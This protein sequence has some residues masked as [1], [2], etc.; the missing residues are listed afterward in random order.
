MKIP[1]GSFELEIPQATLARGL[2]VFSEDKVIQCE[3]VSASLFV[4]TVEGTSEYKVQLNLD[5]QSNVV[6]ADCDCPAFKPKSL[7]KHVVG[8]MFFMN[9]GQF[10]I[11]VRPKR[12]SSE[13][14]KQ[15]TEKLKYSKPTE[16]D[17]LLQ[18]LEPLPVDELKKIICE[19]AKQDKVIKAQLFARYLSASSDQTLERF[20]REIQAIIQLNRGKTS[21]NDWYIARII[22]GQMNGLFKNAQ[23]SYQ[24]G[25]VEAAFNLS[26]AL[27]SEL[28]PVFDYSDDSSGD[29]S[30]LWNEIFQWTEQLVRDRKDQLAGTFVNFALKYCHKGFGFDFGANLVESTFEFLVDDKDFKKLDKLFL[31]IRKGKESDYVKELSYLWE[32]NVLNL[33]GQSELAMRF[34]YEN[35]AMPNMRCILLDDLEKRNEWEE[36]LNLALEGEKI[37]VKNHRYNWSH[38]IEIALRHLGKNEELIARKLKNFE[39]SGF[40]LEEWV[41]F[42]KEFGQDSNELRR[43]ML[44][45][46]DRSNTMATTALAI[47]QYEE[48]FDRIVKFIESKPSSYVI[49]AYSDLIKVNLPKI[50]IKRHMAVLTTLVLGN[51]NSYAPYYHDAVKSLKS[52]EDIIPTEELMSYFENSER[53]N[54]KK[55]VYKEIL[56]PELI[57]VL[58][59]RGMKV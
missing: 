16:E 32:Y 43:K 21:R 57:R 15:S 55:K 50:F 30:G 35:R 28:M 1:L 51:H 27:L 20:Q 33:R 14:K 58:E 36:Y 25:D 47:W 8:C 24:S 52:I 17:R 6:H 38:N 12:K 3:Q 5:G 48:E 44:A 18:L 34:C 11:D 13:S 49:D 41:K 53:V 4:F 54:L 40:R 26:C 46:L 42:K 39:V 37:P 2:R 7:C 19:L 9:E 29:L 59:M 56:R 22:S 10:K 23:S 45:C 31:K